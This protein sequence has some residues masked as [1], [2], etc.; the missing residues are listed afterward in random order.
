MRDVGDVY[1]CAGQWCDV[2]VCVQGSGIM[3]DVCVCVQ[4]SGMMGDVG[5]VCRVV[6]SCVMRVCAG[7][8]YHG[9]CVCRAVV[10]CVMWVMCMCV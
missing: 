6:V 2:Y 4:G 9:G 1:V 8:W 3:R 7:Q 5:G 10:S